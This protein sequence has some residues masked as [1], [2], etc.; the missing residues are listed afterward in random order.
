MM[1]NQCGVVTS[2]AAG[3]EV[4]VNSDTMIVWKFAA[5]APNQLPVPET[6]D[7]ELRDSVSGAPLQTIATSVPNL[8]YYFWNVGARTAMGDDRCIF[9]G[10]VFNEHGRAHLVSD[11][12]SVVN[13]CRDKPAASSGG[14][15]KLHAK[16]TLCAVDCDPVWSVSAESTCNASQSRQQTNCVSRSQSCAID[17]V[18]ATMARMSLDDSRAQTSQSGERNRAADQQRADSWDESSGSCDSMVTRAKRQQRQDDAESGEQGSRSLSSSSP[19]LGGAVTSGMLTGNSGRRTRELASS[20]SDRAASRGNASCFT[21]LQPTDEPSSVVHSNN[22]GTVLWSEYPDFIYWAV[23]MD[24]KTIRRALRSIVKQQ[25]VG[26]DTM[27][28]VGWTAGMF[29]VRYLLMLY[30]KKHITN[31]LEQEIASGQ[32]TPHCRLIDAWRRSNSFWPQRALEAGYEIPRLLVDE[33][34]NSYSNRDG[35]ADD[36]DAARS[37]AKRAHGGRT[38]SS[39][40]KDRRPQQVHDERGD[41]PSAQRCR[42]SG[43]RRARSAL[44]SVT[45]RD[46]EVRQAMPV[47]KLRRIEA[48]DDVNPHEIAKGRRTMRLA[49]LRSTHDA[50]TRA[51]LCKLQHA[52]RISVNSTRAQLNEKVECRDAGKTARETTDASLQQ[53]KQKQRTSQRHNE[54]IAQRSQPTHRLRQPT[55]RVVP[56]M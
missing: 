36:T 37:I 42:T 25:D 17:S 54:Q 12:F 41:V 19:L 55:R 30:Y 46:S 56:Q 13:A 14:K 3:S 24:Q 9:I 7:I 44:D 6:V 11:V 20:R 16:R 47:R 29:S 18:A 1:R 33:R 4:M 45:D 53:S 23:H 51:D 39:I 40:A 43:V 52:A 26:P 31:R 28:D 50:R 5:P 27:L 34:S 48:T 10:S 22:D 32:Y 2:P 49:S 8:G 15:A 38:A 35:F 21:L